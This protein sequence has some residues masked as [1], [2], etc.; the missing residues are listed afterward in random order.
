MVVPG[1]APYGALH[2]FPVAP[3]PPFPFP[4]A[5]R[6]RPPSPPRQLSEAPPLGLPLRGVLEQTLCVRAQPPPLPA[7][8]FISATQLNIFS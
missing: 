1:F 6:R 2:F 8:H 7:E 4:P 3:V 5:R